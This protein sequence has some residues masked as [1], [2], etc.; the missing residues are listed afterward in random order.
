MKYLI[1]SIILASRYLLLPLYLGMT[2]AMV[3]FGFKFFQE[4]IHLFQK[5]SVIS[6]SDLVLGALALI[7]LM[8]VANLLI[9]VIISGYENFVSPIHVDSP[10]EK[11]SWLG[12]L[13]MNTIKIKVATS[14]VGISSIHL[15]AAFLN[16]KEKTTE[17]MLWL[18]ITHMVFVGSSLLLAYIDRILYT[19]HKDLNDA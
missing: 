7:D 4:L 3:L 13:D 10:D 14:L 5:V 8:L 1:Q 15:L 18:V 2:A 19:K 12:T 16:I 9:M 6:E 17:H 11:P